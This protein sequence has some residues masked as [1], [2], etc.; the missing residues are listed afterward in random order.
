MHDPFAEALPDGVEAVSL[1]AL[2]QGSDFISLHAPLSP[3]TRHAIDA[4]R[5]ALV[6]P[7]ALLVNT[8]RG[9]LVDEAALVD[10]L[11][12]R[13]LLGAGLDVF[14]HEPLPATSP[15]HGLANVVLSDHTG[16]YSQESVRDLQA[17]AAAE[18]VR[19]LRGEAPLHWLNRW[20]TEEGTLQ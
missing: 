4:R 6:R 1:D 10:A 19:M 17:K 14:E 18:A 9:P 7:A 13:A 5:V 20:T 15:L 12:R 11:E 16:W 8:A 2:C 3:A